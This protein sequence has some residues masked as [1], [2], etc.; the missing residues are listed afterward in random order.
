[1]VS[2]MLNELDVL[3]DVT[4]RL[5]KAGLLYMLTGSLA[6]NYYAEPRM[7]R[8]ID[9]VVALAAEDARRIGELFSPDY[10]VSEEAAASAISRGSVFNL[11]HLGTAIKVDFIVRKSSEY[12]RLEFERRRQTVIDGLRVWIV[13]KEDLIVSKLFWAKDSESEMQLRDIKNLMATSCDD[14]YI[15]RW[16]RQLGLEELWRRCASE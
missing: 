9:L 14:G 13:S 10:Y 11:I 7:T 5:D 15:E 3:R 16:V 12:R 2:A 4:S 1:M 8:D 6:M